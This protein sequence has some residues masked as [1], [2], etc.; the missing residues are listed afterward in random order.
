MSEKPKYNQPFIDPPLKK[1]SGNGKYIKECYYTC[2]E[3]GET[4]YIPMISYY[5][6]KRQLNNKKRLIFC[7]WNCMRAYEKR[8]EI[9][10]AEKR[11]KRDAAWEEKERE[12]QRKKAARQAERIRR[13]K[14]KEKERRAKEKEK[15]RL[16]KMREQAEKEKIEAKKKKAATSETKKETVF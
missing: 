3:C 5:I 15:E 1:A 10:E 14:Q 9:V 13:E 4:I 11:A 8:I 2:A 6:Y 16:K 7:G 12:R